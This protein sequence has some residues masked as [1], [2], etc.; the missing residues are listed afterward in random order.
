MCFVCLLYLSETRGTPVA[1]DTTQKYRKMKEMSL[2]DSQ[3]WVQV[4]EAT[5]A[6]TGALLGHLQ[7]GGAQVHAGRSCRQELLLSS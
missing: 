4:H 5:C 2:P 1:V 3:I 6:G 7:L